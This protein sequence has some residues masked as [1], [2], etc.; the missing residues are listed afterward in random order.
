MNLGLI[1]FGSHLQNKIINSFLR[2]KTINVKCFYSRNKIKSRRLEKNFKV[3]FIKDLDIFFQQEIDL[4][5]INVPP[6]FFLHLR[7]TILQIHY[8]LDVLI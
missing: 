1:G 2:S 7:S 6:E 3:K 8:P 4:V 5:Y